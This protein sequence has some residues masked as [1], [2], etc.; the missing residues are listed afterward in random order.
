MNPNTKAL[1]IVELNEEGKINYFIHGNSLSISA[2]TDFVSFK[3]KM[4]I[5]NKSL[6]FLSPTALPEEGV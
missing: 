4:D 2:I 5:S 1:A 3:T 6:P